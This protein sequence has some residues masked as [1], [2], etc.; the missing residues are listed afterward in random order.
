V[1]GKRRAAGIAALALATSL[2][3]TACGGGDSGGSGGGSSDALTLGVIVPPTSFAAANA[4]WANESPYIQAV[5]D[6]LLRESPDA[7]VEPW[8]ATEWSYD[9]SKTVLTMK[10]RDDVTF[11]DGTKFDAS[12]A[13]QN[14]LRF[15]AGT[16]PNASYLA[17]VADATAVDPTTLQITLSQPDPALLNYLA[18]NAGAQESPAA[19]GKPDEQTTP[20]GSG[21]YLLDTKNTVVGSKYVFTKN[22]DYWAPDEQH[23]DNLT[24]NVYDNTQTQVNAIQGGQVDG[25]NLITNEANDQVEA[26]GY[27]LVTHELD[28]AGLILFDRAGQLAPELG[29]VQ[30][31]QAIAHAVD[32]DAILKAANNGLGTVTGQIFGEKNPGYDESLDDTYDYDPA[33][34]KKLLAD[35]GY[36]DG[37]TLQMPEVQI[38][39]TVAY[40]LLKQYLGDV[41]ITL[42]YTQLPLSQAIPDLLS[43]KYPASF[44][45]LQQD[46]T[47][48]QVA[49]FSIA[50]GATFN[51]FHQPDATVDGLI[52]TIQTGSQAESDAAAQ[53]L[54]QYVVDQAWY[55]PFYRNQGTF[56]AASDLE[57]THQS[58]NA[59]PYLQ[60]IQPAS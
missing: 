21:P 15:K 22:P 60:N 36:P 39:S 4:A 25:V 13:A 26:A 37:F 1:L 2:V 58:D 41:G 29:N 9:D 28:W 48:W 16:S 14:I 47:A 27:Q 49:Q 52:Q 32:R 51:V 40:D 30:V 44:F 5:Y 45:V 38:G 57:V 12:V 18:Q 56:A 23:F 59:Y 31:R 43:A 11:S 8:L 53:Q 3:M 34:A 46:P 35:A 42:D 19:F 55:V 33:A 24:I 50:Q 17:N 54:N 10:L 20:V 6:S 7:E